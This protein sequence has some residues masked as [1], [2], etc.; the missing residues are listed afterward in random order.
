MN[1]PT[2]QPTVIYAAT[3]LASLVLSLVAYLQSDIINNDGILYVD[4]AR[5]FVA[6]GIGDAFATFNWPL[7]GI[8]IGITHQLTQLDYESAA[9]LLN[10]LLIALACVAFV[11]T[12]REIARDGT[13]MWVAAVLILALPIVNDYRDFVIRDFGYWAFLLLT[14]SLF[15]RS[16]QND[17]L[18]YAALWQLA[19]IL[20]IAF[21]IEGAAFLAVPVI[22][23]LVQERDTRG[24][25]RKIF[26]S[27]FVFVACGLIGLIAFSGLGVLGIEANAHTLLL[28]L[29]YVSPS[30]IATGLEQEA[31]TLR[32]QLEYLSST[33]DA[34]L[35]LA[36]GLVALAASK[37]LINAVPPYCVVAVY[38]R[39]RNWLPA[40]AG[41]RAVWVFFAL[42][43]AA[44]LALV[45][46]R[47]FLS[48][49]YTVAAVLLLSLITFAYVDRGLQKLADLPDRRWLVAAWVL[50]VVIFADGV[51]STGASKRA[52]KTGSQWALQELERT[53]P[54]LCNEARLRFYTRQGCELIEREPLMKRLS[55]TGGASAPATLLLWVGRKDAELQHVLS[56]GM[57]LEP[58]KKLLNRRGDALVIYAA[59]PAQTAVE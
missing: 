55:G 24:R 43:V 47:Y 59:E 41:S 42:A 16:T 49:R 4:V 56:A 38:G 37:V 57:P 29:S 27:T 39:Y 20:A 23:H 34:V 31:I 40:T 25:V 21:R 33:G 12:Y 50:I 44:A 2:K 46:S 30:A 7:Y 35:V 13:R 6:G 15:I 28:W 52:I 36:S 45:A 19:A 5:A 32:Q 48:S 18:V 17:S 54:W 1:P 3:F 58:I 22:Y 14:V 53:T 8:L 11:V 10:A 26:R 9:H 51:I